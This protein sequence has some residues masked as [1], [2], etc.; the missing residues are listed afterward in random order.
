MK[1]QDR[2]ALLLASAIKILND[3]KKEFNMTTTRTLTENLISS[4]PNAGRVRKPKQVERRKDDTTR[5]IVERVADVTAEKVMEKITEH[6]EVLAGAVAAA[7]DGPTGMFGQMA[8]ALAHQG[9]DSTGSGVVK[10]DLSS[11]NQPEGKTMT[12]TEMTADEKAAALKASQEARAAKAAKDKADKEAAA[13]LKAEAK[14]AKDK[15]REEAKVKAEADRKAKAEAREADRKAK[16]EQR[17]AERAAALSGSN[18]AY[19]G[20]MLALAERVKAGTYVKG[21]LGQLRSNDE[22]AVAL[23]CVKP[24]DVVKLAKLVLQ[25]T[26]DEAK[27]YDGLNIGQQS[28][29]WRNR[30]RGAI[31]QG[32]EVGPEG[33]KVKVTIDLVKQIRDEHGLVTEP[34]APKAPKATVKPAEE[35]AAQEAP[36]AEAQAN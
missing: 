21:A 31:R 19:T 15:E 12:T 26:L 30:L 32:R 29:N 3:P 18:R 4:G 17:E 14:A 5:A 35:A 33:A 22:V 10:S 11:T 23:D 16:A 25:P 9:V 20:S 34:P 13:K 7:I 6:P 2:S 24:A 8:A 1:K 27:R 36:A 28:M